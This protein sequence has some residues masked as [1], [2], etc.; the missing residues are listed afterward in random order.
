MNAGPGPEGPPSRPRDRVRQVVNAVNLS[1]LIGLALALVGRARLS[2]GPRFTLLATEVRL[3]LRASAMTVG[4]VVLTRKSRERMLERPALLRHELR[5]CVQYAWCLGV[6]M[7]VMYAIAAGWSLVFTGDPASRNVF[8]RLAGL[9][10]GNYKERPLRWHRRKV[11][12]DRAD[13]GSRRDRATPGG[14][15]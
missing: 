9:A 12:R 4:D 13:R 10:D 1:T 7:L 8:E 2:A 15:Q 14:P 11:H 6:V 3:P 5:H